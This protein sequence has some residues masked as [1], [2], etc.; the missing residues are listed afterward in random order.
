M[1][2]SIRT[3]IS[4]ALYYIGSWFQSL[5]YRFD[6]AADWAY[7]IPFVGPYIASPLYRVADYCYY[8]YEYFGDL[9]SG[10]LSL[11]NWLDAV[12][13]RLGDLW[14]DLGDL[15]DYAHDYLWGKIYDALDLADDAWDRAVTAY[16]KARDAWYYAT[17]WLTDRANEA[18]ARAGA[19]WGTVTNWLKQQAIDAWNKAVWAYEQ[20][21]AAV[22]AKAQEIYAWVKGIP[23]E[24]RDFVDGVVTA[25]GAVTTDI[26]QTLINT[27]LAAIAGPFN[28][29]NLWF[30]DIQNFF[31]DPLD[32]LSD[33]FEDRFFGPKE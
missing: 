14:D 2:S 24:I 22:T 10:W 9:R 5:S 21:A 1:P 11:C 26:V 13:D 23:A 30:D 3:A 7:D 16:Q 32:W 20:I 15:W 19:V 6:D 8:I 31:N 4:N 17:G 29:I 33:K 27:A 25:I 12:W 28:L 18:W